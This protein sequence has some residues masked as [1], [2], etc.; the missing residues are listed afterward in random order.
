MTEINEIANKLNK[1]WVTGFKALGNNPTPLTKTIFIKDVIPNIDNYYLTIKADGLRCFLLIN[2]SYIKYITSENTKY[3]QIPNTFSEQYI[4]DCE[5]VNDII[6]IF[7]VIV[8]KNEN[9]AFEAFTS[10]YKKMLDF[11]TILNNKNITDIRIKQFYKLNIKDY[12]KTIINLHNYKKSYKTDGLIFVESTKDYN[13]TVNLKWK[14]PEMLTIDFLAIRIKDNQY[15][16]LNGIKSNIM[17]QFRLTPNTIFLNMVDSLL[18]KANKDYAPVPFYN[19]LKPSIYHYIHTNSEDLNGHIIELSLDKNI[20]W[21]FHRIRHD[22]D[23]E[24]K[25]GYYYG[26]NYKVA[27]TTLASIL[28]PL[29]LKELTA[30]CKILTQSIY[31]KKQ[32]S[33]YKSVKHFNNYVKML[34]IKRYKNTHIIDLASGRGGD[35]NKYIEIEAKSLLMLEIDKDA[36]EELINRKY[37]ILTKSSNLGCNLAI[38][39][40]DLN[41]SYKN[42]ITKITDNF[43]NINDFFIEDLNLNK[44]TNVVFCHFALHYLLKSEKSA[45]NIVS[46]ISHYLEKN[47][48]FVV[49]IFNGQSVFNLLKKNKGKWE[50]G[51]KY[52][53][54]FK[55]NNTIFSGFKNT[56]DVLLPLADKPYEE[57]LIDLLA[58]D[59][60]FKKEHIF[61]T[62]EKD[63]GDMLEEYSNYHKEQYNNLS[64]D[65]KI[66]I[67]LYKY[68]IYTKSC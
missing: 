33:E 68:V 57:P 10:R 41:T 23:M 45:Q 34:L 64:P 61:R 47:G 20:N 22:R 66:F 2:E 18:I 27:E 28:N 8:Y 5:L 39:Q 7:D 17:K 52:M 1:K 31:F 50:S 11:E 9:I 19:S 30:P 14:P 60:L 63:F 24:L 32:D 4:F 44:K 58:L 38:L 49:T 53:I 3:V 56:I 67:G 42:N 51:K 21:V 46:F 54:K 36:I 26:N 37:S 6:Y 16:L 59:K 25:N 35:L 65:D 29:L 43:I 13:L 62:E 40:M 12:Q 15:I 48:S 55:T